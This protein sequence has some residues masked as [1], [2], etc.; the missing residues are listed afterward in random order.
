MIEM[1]KYLTEILD[2]EEQKI[3]RNI[4]ALGFLCSVI[5]IFSFL[6]TVYFIPIALQ[7]A[8]LTAKVQIYM[9]L[10]IFLLQIILELYRCKLSNH[11][12]YNGAQKLS[13]KIYELFGKEDLEH[14]NQKSVMQTLAI[15][16][17]DTTKC[18]SI[19]FSCIEIGTNIFTILGYTTIL[20][21]LSSW[22]GVLGCALIIGLMAGVFLWYCIQMEIYGEKCRRY[23]IK[24]NS[25]IT[26]GYGIFEEMKIS[27]SIE[28]VLQ[29]YNNASMKYAQVQGE[30]SYKIDY[31][32]V[33]MNLWS[34]AIMLAIF[35]VL[36]CVKTDLTTLI[37]TTAYI[38]ILSRMMPAT[39][40]IIGCMNS[41]RYSKKSYEVVR[42][43]LARYEKLKEKEKELR[44]IRKK[45]IEFQK[46]LSVRNLTFGYSGMD[47]IFEDASIDIPT[48]KSVAIIGTSGIG[49]TTFLSLV[50]GLLKPQSG[51]IL[52]DDY[53]IVSQTDEKGICQAN[54]GNIV[55]YIPQTV[56]MNGETVRNNVALF[57]DQ[58][59]IDDKRVEQC[60]K[61]AQVWEDIAKMPEGIHTLISERGTTI[62]GGQRQRIALARAL[63]KD[64]ELLIM[65]EATA[66]LDMETEK[67]VIDS[68]RQVRKNKT[69]LMV[70]HHMSLTEECDIIYKIENQ[71]FIRVK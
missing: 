46:G 64:F 37:P 3:W 28:P 66:A 54:I 42:D 7:I 70:T 27:D 14:H 18:V 71:K 63:Y 20:I 24:A 60:L 65:D 43:C 29:K 1:F 39:Y 30:Y 10:I 40:N 34:K 6:T 44:E 22:L 69:L 62:S 33:L 68:I 55:S 21:F 2:K 47:K 38:S 23:E 8:P 4:S 61:C 58:D 41:I 11:F 51:K 36:F 15:V 26:L 67:A 48:G 32:K 12:L 45:K 59:T 19:I 5:E 56:Y 57:V 17:S 53:D 52:Y 35:G 16:R 13:I 31:V 49:K 25:Q 50:M 9:V